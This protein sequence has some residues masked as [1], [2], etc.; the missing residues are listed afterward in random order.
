MYVNVYDVDTNGQANR[1]IPEFALNVSR[2]I[3][4]SRGRNARKR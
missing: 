1:N 2:H 3:G 4:T